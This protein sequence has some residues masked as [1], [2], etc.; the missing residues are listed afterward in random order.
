M[1]SVLSS[2]L[3]LVMISALLGVMLGAWVMYVLKDSISEG[4]SVPENK[5][6]RGQRAPARRDG[7]RHDP[8]FR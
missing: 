1:M 2:D 8:S 3:A 4:R 7:L 6:T 5:L